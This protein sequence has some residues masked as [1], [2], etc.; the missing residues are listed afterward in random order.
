MDVA[1]P[2][3]Q[4]APSKMAGLTP[5]GQVAR[6]QVGE[7]GNGAA[8]VADITHVH[9]SSVCGADIDVPARRVAGD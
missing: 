7:C 9:H 2:V 1:E 6:T 4:L 8:A 5:A 3:S